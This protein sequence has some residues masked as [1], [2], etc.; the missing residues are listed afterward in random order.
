MIALLTIF[1]LSLS[2]ITA[3]GVVRARNLFAAVMLMSIFSLLVASVFLLLDAPDVALTEAAVGAGISAVL[4]LS[5]LALTAEEEQV[6]GVRPF[7]A[8]VVVVVMAGV[9]LYAASDKPALGDPDAPVHRHVAGEY[10]PMTRE[11]IDIPNVVTAVLASFRGYD[12]L[13]EVIVVLTAA[14]GVLFLI[15]PDAP[16]GGQ[17]PSRG[18]LS[19]RGLKHHQPLRIVGKLAIPFILLF[20]LYVQFHGE[21][22]PGGGFQAGALLAAGIILFGLLE[23]RQAAARVIPTGVLQAM[24]AGGALLFGAVGVLGMALGGNFLDYS[25]LRADPVKAQQ[26]GI[27]VIEA[28]VGITVAGVLLAI[29]HAFAARGEP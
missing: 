25:L 21:Y 13:G 18:G 28:G 9:V 6:G 14:I 24:A 2:V 1:L 3:V 19:Q 15:G 8:L 27:L 7:L 29:Y 16:K 22:S 11:Q 23:G 12:T 26:L 4:L 5:A 10:F 20:A 17:S